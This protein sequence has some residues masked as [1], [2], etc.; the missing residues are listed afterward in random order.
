MDTCLSISSVLSFGL[1]DVIF[2]T[3][4]S[5]EAEGGSGKGGVLR[6]ENYGFPT[7]MLQSIVSAGSI[8][9]LTPNTTLV[10]SPT[11]THTA[12]LFSCV[13]LFLV[14]LLNFTLLF[15]VC[16]CEGHETAGMVSVRAVYEIAQV[17]AQDECFKIRNASLETVVKS[18]IGS[19]Q[20]LGIKIVNE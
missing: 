3:Y 13:K 10:P 12:G 16:V 17:K 15:C 14:C 6:K 19:A 2:M 18:I 11:H 5:T 8:Q 7:F 9:S 1:I 4:E 20:S